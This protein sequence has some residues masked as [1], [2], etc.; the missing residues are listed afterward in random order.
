MPDYRIA[1]VREYRHVYRALL[2]LEGEAENEG[3]WNAK[4]ADNHENPSP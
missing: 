2:P 1:T 3:R 4:R